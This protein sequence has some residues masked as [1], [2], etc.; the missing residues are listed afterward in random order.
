ML[1]KSERDLERGRGL[2][3]DLF[4]NGDLDGLDGDGVLLGQFC[5]L[6]GERDYATIFPGAVR[7]IEEFNFCCVS[8]ASRYFNDVFRLALNNSLL[9]L[10]VFLVSF[11]SCHLLN[12]KLG[13]N[14]PLLRV[15]I[16]PSLK[17]IEF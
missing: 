4:L 16:L 13:V 10:E 14:L 12:T 11:L 17:L 6:V 2:S 5:L 7:V 9:F 15:F 8:L 1:R 3:S